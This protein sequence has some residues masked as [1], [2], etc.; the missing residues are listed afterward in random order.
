MAAW[1]LPG[2]RGDRAGEG[3][4]H[5]AEE[6]ALEQVLRDGAAVDGDERARCARGER[7]WIS[8]ATSSLPV[9]VSPVIEHRDVGGGDLL[10][11]PVDL[12]HRPRPRR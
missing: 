12:A 6:L 11:A 5:V 8:R 2:L 7:R 3:A 10:D 9:P 1:N 4:L